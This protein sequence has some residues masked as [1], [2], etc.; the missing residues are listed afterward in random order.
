MEFEPTD[1]F[2]KLIVA[3]LALSAAG[4]TD[5][6]AAF[7]VV[8]AVLVLVLVVVEPPFA[9]VTPAQ[10]ERIAAENRSVPDRNRMRT[11]EIGRAQVS[12]ETHDGFGFWAWAIITGEV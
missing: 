11:R 2:P 8:F 7:V 6:F 5:E 1:T 3:G 9:L 4:A 12:R 10:P